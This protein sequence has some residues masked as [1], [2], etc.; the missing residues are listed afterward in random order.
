MWH[1]VPWSRCQGDDWSKVRLSD[2]G[3]LFQ[4]KRFGDSDS[5]YVPVCI[6]VRN[7]VVGC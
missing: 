5:M 4:P 6:E 3:G 1:T 7:S 2:L